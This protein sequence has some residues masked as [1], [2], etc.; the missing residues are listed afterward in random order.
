MAEDSDKKPGKIIKDASAKSNKLLDRIRSGLEEVVAANE[1]AANKNVKATDSLTRINQDN[2]KKQELRDNYGIEARLTQQGKI[3][4][5]ADIQERQ[6]NQAKAADEL[7]AAGQVELANTIREQLETQKKAITKNDGN[8]KNLIGANNLVGER[9]I[10]KADRDLAETDK[11]ILLGELQT[12]SFGNMIAEMK[13]NTTALSLSDDII[14]K[15]INDL[16]PTFGG[17]LDPFF[18][19][20]ND[21]LA[22]ISAAEAEGLIS[23]AEANT[24][25]RELLSATQ[26]REKEREAQEAAELQSMALT[27]IGDGFDRFG[28]KFSNFAQGAVKSGGLLGGLLALVIGVVSPEKFTEIV[29]AITDGFMEIVKGFMALL[30]GDFTTFKEKIGENFLLFG[31]LI[32]GVAAY[33]GGPL[34]KAF[35]GVFKNLATVVRAVRLFTLKTLP[36]FATSMISSLTS[37]GTMMGFASGSLMVVLGPVLAIVAV[38]GLLYAG[39]KALSSNLGEGASVMDTLKVAAMYLVD[40]LSMLVNGITFIPRK[41]IG[42]L[43]PRVAKFLFGDDVDTSMFD[44]ISEGLDTGR[45]ARA[46]EEIRLKN[47]KEAAE[48]KLEEQMEQNVEG[49]ILT[50][51][52]TG[53]E[54]GRLDAENDAAKIGAAAGGQTVNAPQITA[55]TQQNT[56]STTNVKYEAPSYSTLQLQQFYAGRA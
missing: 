9:I 46:A 24:Y 54:L 19:E 4:K 29:V 56:Q 14:E 40:F 36:R 17:E 1:E 39:F 27:K 12:D 42:F 43:G 25:R 3:D 18:T 5:L 13:E 10:Q 20:A 16:G 49:T 32:L 23:T 55:N 2:A 53:L 51:P 8:L 48:K 28:D 31:G 21:Q 11:L 45:G 38:I 34:I 50:D 15:A 52:T 44:K 26:D 47:E 22:K 30:S 37:M 7:E 35:G 6:L 33:F 41:I